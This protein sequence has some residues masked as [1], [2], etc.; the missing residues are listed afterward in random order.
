MTLKKWQTY[1]ETEQEK[2]FAAFPICRSY[3]QLLAHQQPRKDLAAKLRLSKAQD[4]LDVA[5]AEFYKSQSTESICSFWSAQ[6][7]KRLNEA[8]NASFGN[9]QGW[10]VF[11]YGKLGS[12]EL[13]LSSDVDLVFI[14]E[15][16][17][18]PQE[19]T[20][21]RNFRALVSDT[22]DLGFGHRLDFDLRPGG[23]MGPIVASFE[24]WQDYF[25]NYGEAWE[26][27]SFIRFRPVWGDPSLQKKI[28]AEAHRLTFRKYLDFS[29]I[30]E[31]K[32]LRQ[33][34]HEQNWQRPGED[35]IDLKLGI[36]GIRDLEL[37]VHTLQVIYGGKSTEV[38]TNST[39]EALQKLTQIGALQAK[40]RD[41][42]LEHYWLLRHFENLVQAYGDQQTHL[43][44]PALIAPAA[45]S[46][47]INDLKPAMQRC[48][49]LVSTL[50]GPLDEFRKSLPA[51][52][53]DQ[54]AWLLSIGVRQDIMDASWPQLFSQEILSRQRERDDRMRR[55]FIFRFLSRTHELGLDINLVLPRLAEL[56][57][58]IRAKAALFH[59]LV[60]KPQILDRL[61]HLLA[62]S[63]YFSQIL[64][65]R[66][67]LL[68]S[69]VFEQQ[70][71]HELKMDIEAKAIH[72]RERRL[73]AELL[74]GLD[75]LNGLDV[76]KMT[77]K[78][79]QTADAIVSELLTELKDEFQ[80]PVDLI[81]LG[82]WGGEELGLN[83]DLDFILVTPQ[84][85]SESDLKL[86]R[87]FLNRLTGGESIYK[88]DLRLKPHGGSG[89]MMT[90]LP[91]LLEFLRNEAPPWQRQSY[92]KARSLLGQINVDEIYKICA[93]RGLSKDELRELTRIQKE[94]VE[95]NA[96][97]SL[98]SQVKY[99][100][101]GMVEIELAAQAF[102]LFHHCPIPGPRL[103]QHAQA[104]STSSH[105]QASLFKTLYEN[106]QFLRRLEQL[107][108]LCE[109]RD[110]VAKCL[111][112]N[113]K[114]LAAQIS[115]CLQ[116]NQDGLECL[117]PRRR[118]D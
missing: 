58:K 37:F 19:T 11:V 49:Q 54:K 90:S 81:A 85:P 18:G 38:R 51:S 83:S 22:T 6:T 16:E 57:R 79:S 5:F 104:I 70:S 20:A 87:R 55:L 114:E 47:E 40:D 64:I 103:S 73:L 95:Q 65:H 26:R 96:G 45:S 89:L 50:L 21:L 80:S 66:P 13:N 98:L 27:L 53:E 67:E 60:N 107:N 1:S 77:Q 105:T 113:E 111:K 97:S 110:E 28:L 84:A 44:R 41:F 118:S 3:S 10:A 39:T 31:F 100:F 82:K 75:F 29:L 88:V 48:H 25:S 117:D 94:L 115:K 62:L 71:D 2:I 17:F 101:G 32:E 23:R 106:Y 86:G 42:L 61:C 14:S 59:M 112:L 43:L 99:A 30:E 36:G 92:L 63:Q 4:F 12:Q 9:A 76:E 52:E 35:A 15:R 109:S 8:L 78:L 74:G 91:D 116:E 7:E 24:Q 102:L 108:R 33:K 56:I 72:W 69:F 34:I 46:Q 93:V 68:D